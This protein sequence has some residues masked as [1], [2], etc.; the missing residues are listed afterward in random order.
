MAQGDRKPSPRRAKCYARVI[1]NEPAPHP[2]DLAPRYLREPVAERRC[3]APRR[4]ADDLQ[5]PDDV[6]LMQLA[7]EERRLVEPVHELLCAA[8][9][10]HDV[11]DVFVIRH[12]G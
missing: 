3:A 10:I 6:R 8:R 11:Q 4:L 2:H 9:R 12:D 1:V 7:R 5:L